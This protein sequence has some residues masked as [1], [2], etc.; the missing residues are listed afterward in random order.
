MQSA[1][2]NTETFYSTE[3]Q[4]LVVLNLEYFLSLVISARLANTVSLYDLAALG[5]LCHA[6]KLK[7]PNV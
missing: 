3:K 6:G 5:A 2:R 4:L 7:L 1:N